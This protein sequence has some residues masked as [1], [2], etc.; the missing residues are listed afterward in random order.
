MSRTRRWALATGALVVA[1]GLL[2]PAAADWLVTRDGSR[3]ETVGPWR[4]ESR[5]VVFKRPD[6]TLGSLRLSDVDL[7]ASRRLT[8]E[9]TAREAAA[10]RR[11]R[12][13]PEE[14]ERPVIA[15]LTEKDLP[16]VDRPPA[17]ERSDGEATDASRQEPSDLDIVSFREVSGA[18]SEG[19]AFTG[20]VRNRTEHMA[21]GVGVTAVL[22][23]EEGEEIRRGEA[24]LTSNALPSGQS[25]GFRADF[26]GVYHYARV[27]FDV[28]GNLLR[29][30]APDVGETAEGAP[31]EVPEEPPPGR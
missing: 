24:R 20:A 6:G 26:P 19:V 22:Y 14:R 21:V 16:P 8:D 23:D 5:L 4:V 9:M 10:E 18:D 3:V 30:A 1:V 13:A 7:E 11:E 17:A 25:A 27:V 2:L 12:E 28:T 15:R 29:T 31:V